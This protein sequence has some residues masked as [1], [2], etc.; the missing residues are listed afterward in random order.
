MRGRA[1]RFVP[2]T[3]LG[4]MQLLQ[5][6]GVVMKDKN[7][8]VLGDSNVV[9]MPLAMLFRDAGAATV[10]VIHRTSFRE[11]FLDS[12]S[13]EV[14]GARGGARGREGSSICCGPAQGA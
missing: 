5:R 7:V 2:C 1:A 14:G 12:V 9:G 8:V 10:T 11:L 4:C 13:S 6:S 3:A